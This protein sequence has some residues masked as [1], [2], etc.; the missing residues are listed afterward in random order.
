MLNSHPTLHPLMSPVSGGGLAESVTVRVQEAI[1]LGLLAP[2]QQLPS[3]SALSARLGVSTVTLR[4][5]LATLR[6]QGLVE[7]RRGRNGGTFVI[8]A[9]SSSEEFLLARLRDTTVTELRDLG[10]EQMAIASMSAR[11]AAT[12]STDMNISQFHEFTQ[13]V[14]RARTREARAQAYSR[15]HIEVSL[16][17][18]SERLTRAQ[19]RMQGEFG[20]FLWVRTEH[21][22]DPVAVAE[23]LRSIARAIEME[24]PAGARRLAEELAEENSRWLI[25]THLELLET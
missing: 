21:P 7:T 14:E 5:A 17:S 18:Q 9:V 8:G 2:G 24:D 11:L 3:E 4:E 15:F 23:S 19:L 22:R 16:A 1:R 25:G 20:E 12:R 6:E 13:Q 10:D